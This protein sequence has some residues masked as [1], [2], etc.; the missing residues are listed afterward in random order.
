MPDDS[1]RPIARGSRVR[2]SQGKPTYGWVGGTIVGRSGLTGLVC[3]RLDDDQS[4]WWLDPREV[5][6]IEGE[7]A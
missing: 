6:V 4:V 3:V 7:N 1:P 5:Q 2:V